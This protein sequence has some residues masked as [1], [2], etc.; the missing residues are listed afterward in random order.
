[1]KTEMPLV[2]GN[3]ANIVSGNFFIF[4]AFD[5]GD[6]IA[7]NKVEASNELLIKQ[8]T[9]SKYFKNY[10]IPLAV[11][12]PQASA[13]SKC[14][15]ATL[16]S[17][18]VISLVYKVPF[19]D[20]L[21]TMKKTL[22]TLDAEFRE[23]SIADAHAIF[24]KIKNYIKQARFFH[25]RNSYVVIQVDQDPQL[26]VVDLKQNH[27]ST[28][29]SLL[30]F[31]T[32]SL[33]E[34][35]KDAIMESATGYYRGDLIIIDTAAAFVYDEDYVEILDLFEFAN[36]QQLEL[37]YYDRILDQQL[38][39]VYQQEAWSLPITA[40]IPFISSLAKD[41]ISN[42]DRLKVEISVIIER[43]E[44]SV[45]TAG[46][47][48]VAETYTLLV[49][50]LDLKSWKDSLNTKLDIIKDVLSVYQSKIDTTRED[51]LSVLVIVLIFIELV[52]GILSYLK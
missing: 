43:I 39:V 3:E 23:Q 4:Y 10:H 27:G 17:F 21:E 42:L 16:H 51:L 30:Q 45:K 6:D 34:Y 44:S 33:S 41:P 37:H 5:V 18:G 38:N 19:K 22:N 35:Q 15:K 2:E 25:L 36:I 28:I 13:N 14:I 8:H 32:E 48:Y 52:V 20:T 47:V 24:S 46:D 31:E 11:D 49:E 29:V 9:L 1:M 12:L 40:Y 50:K 26:S 7:L